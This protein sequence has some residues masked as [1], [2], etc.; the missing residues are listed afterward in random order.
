MDDTMKTKIENDNRGLPALY[1]SKR[2]RNVQL[3]E[4]AVVKSSSWTD[5]EALSQ[6]LIDIVSPNEQDLLRQLDGRVVKRFRWT[7][8]TLHVAGKPVE[9][10][11]CRSGSKSWAG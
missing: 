9:S 6:H 1:V 8:V 3:A 4:T 11:P 7:S 5:Q 10:F 2:G